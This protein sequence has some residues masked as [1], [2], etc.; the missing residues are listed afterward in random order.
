MATK[1][2][3]AKELLMSDIGLQMQETID[4]VKIMKGHKAA[5]D[6]L[7]EMEESLGIIKQ[8]Y[9]NGVKTAEDIVSGNEDS[10]SAEEEEV[11]SKADKV[12]NKL[13][14]GWNSEEGNFRRDRLADKLHATSHYPDKDTG[15]AMHHNRHCPE[16]QSFDTAETEANFDL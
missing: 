1:S 5:K 15:G 13:R 6:K 4:K 3:K 8:A 12:I 7:K 9:Y 14:V 16:L 11:K 10:D 2:K